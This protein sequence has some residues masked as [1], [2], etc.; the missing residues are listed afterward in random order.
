M[1]TDPT[2][3]GAFLAA[4]DAPDPFQREQSIDAGRRSWDRIPAHYR[5]AVLDH[6]DAQEWVRSLVAAGLSRGAMVPRISRGPSLLLIG[7]TGTGKTH[8]AYGAI[9]ALTS[10]G[11]S[12]SWEAITAA[13]LYGRLRPRHRVDSEVEF[14]PFLRCGVLVLDD[15]G[16]AKGSE[17][18]EE[19]NYRLINHRYEHEQPTLITSNVPPKDLASALGERVSSRLREMAQRVV[20]RGGDRRKA[21]AA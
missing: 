10:S 17:W 20:L 19:I 5:G 6:P 14:E 8:T 12:C 11:L 4:T 16:A 18:N 13:D 9:R 15:L 7:S 1:T 21:G 3:T 2:I